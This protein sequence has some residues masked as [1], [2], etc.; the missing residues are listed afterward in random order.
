MRIAAA[1]GLSGLLA[2]AGAPVSAQSIQTAL[3]EIIV[4][5]TRRDEVL[6][7]V[8]FNITAITS[9]SMTAKRM[10]RISDLGCWVPGLTVVD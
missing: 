7:R 1:L 10:D 9:E 6:T 3:E 4:T 2:F 5:A 8:P